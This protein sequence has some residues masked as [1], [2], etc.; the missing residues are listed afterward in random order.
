MS[1]SGENAVMKGVIIADRTED[2]IFMTLPLNLVT[3]SISEMKNIY[4]SFKDVNLDKEYDKGKVSS[5]DGLF[6][7]FKLP[8]GLFYV[9]FVSKTYKE[10]VLNEYIEKMNEN[11]QEWKRSSIENGSSSFSSLPREVKQSVY[12]LFDEY[13]NLDSEGKP[14]QKIEQKDNSNNNFLN[15][16]GNFIETENNIAKINEIPPE[17]YEGEV[18]VEINIGNN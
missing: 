15:V 3:S 16:S 5:K 2:K 12:R 8:S 6:Y 4:F 7:Y 10:N 17:Q 11:F 14:I 13:Q 9:A 18:R 1:L